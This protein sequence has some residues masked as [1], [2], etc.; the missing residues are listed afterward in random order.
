MKA[1]LPKTALN[2]LAF[3]LPIQKVLVTIHYHHRG[4]RVLDLPHLLQ[5]NTKIT[6]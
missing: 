3:L 1:V 2:W 5:E 6:H 4:L